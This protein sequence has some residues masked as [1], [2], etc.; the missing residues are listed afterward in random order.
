MKTRI[1]TIEYADGKIFYYAQYKDSLSKE[2]N[3]ALDVF[4]RNP[5]I[6][7]ICLPIFIIVFIIMHFTY[8]STKFSILED[9]K[10]HIDALYEE[11]RLEKEKRENK[12]KSKKV[13]NK[14]YIKY[15]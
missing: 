6:F 7:I 14:T 1:K 4:K 12:R 2:L 11:E 3:D 13:V 8:N 10:N 5:L 9:A 15:P